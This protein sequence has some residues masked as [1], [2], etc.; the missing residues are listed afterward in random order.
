MT[1]SEDSSDP[2]SSFMRTVRRILA[3]MPGAAM[4]VVHHTGWQ[5]GDNK[6]TRERGSSAWRGNSDVTLYLEADEYD[7]QQ[8]MCPLRLSALSVRDAERPMPLRLI[9]RRVELLE[10]LSSDLRRG[11]VTSCIIE[12]DRR[13]REDLKT[14]ARACRRRDRPP[15]PEGDRRQQQVDIPGSDSPLARAEAGR[16]P[17]G[18]HPADESRLDYAT[19]ASTPTLHTH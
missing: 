11:P 19:G 12:A 17:R 2:V 15:R 1:G 14:D 3:A 16:C 10:T 6:R 8:G 18:A 7:T 5:D 9:R 4:M 13:P